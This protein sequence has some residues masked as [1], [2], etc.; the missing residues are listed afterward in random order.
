MYVFI[1]VMCMLYVSVCR[2]VCVCMCVALICGRQEAESEEGMRFE[3]V[4]L[5]THFLQLGP[6]VYSFQTLPKE[7]C[8]W[9]PSIYSAH[10]LM[11][12]V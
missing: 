5:L 3:G 4:F 11:R 10:D 6:K 8:H 7:H 12:G 1:C 2:Y 9:E